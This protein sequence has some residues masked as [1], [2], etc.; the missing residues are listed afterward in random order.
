MADLRRTLRQFPQSEAPPSAGKPARK[1]PETDDG[2]TGGRRPSQRTAG[3]RTPADGTNFVELPAHAPDWMTKSRMLASAL[4]STIAEGNPGPRL[5]ACIEH[6]STQMPFSAR[7]CCQL[8]L[9]VVPRIAA[10]VPS[11]PVTIPIPSASV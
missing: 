3:R 2:K 7:P 10:T 4:E 5:R 9:A 11:P 6:I 8:K 1:A